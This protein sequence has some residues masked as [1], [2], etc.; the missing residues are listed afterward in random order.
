MSTTQVK[1]QCNECGKKFST[2]SL[3]P[4]CPKCG[5]ADVDVRE[6]AAA[7]TPATPESYGKAAERYAKERELGWAVVRLLEDLEC[8]R[9]DETAFVTDTMRK[10]KAL[11]LLSAQPTLGEKGGQP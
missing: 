4:S 5:G 9:T 1:V 10:A 3:S 2:A 7:R 8:T 11:G 6:L